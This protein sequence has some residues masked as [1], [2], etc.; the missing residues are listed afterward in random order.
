MS[1]INKKTIDLRKLAGI[2]FDPKILE[3]NSRVIDEIDHQRAIINHLWDHLDRAKEEGTACF[4]TDLLF[5]WLDSRAEAL[6]IHL[7]TILQNGKGVH[8]EE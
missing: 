2:Q 3:L 8:Y 1:D 4:G 7:N 6:R 5:G